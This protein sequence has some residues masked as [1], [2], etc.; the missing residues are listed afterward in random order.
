MNK[1]VLAQLNN[2]A[3]IGIQRDTLRRAAFRLQN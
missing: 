2:P 3:L 1:G